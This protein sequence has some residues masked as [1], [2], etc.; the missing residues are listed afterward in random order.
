MKLAITLLCENPHRLT[1]LSSLFPALVRES[2][3]LFP[4]VEW[5]V[6]AGAK[7]EWPFEDPRVRIVRDFPANDRLPARLAA[8]HFKVGP[9][10]AQMGARALLTVG[11]VPMRAPLPVAMHVVALQHL[12][13]AGRLGWLRARYRAWALRHGVR[14]AH[15]IIAN[16]EHTRSQLMGVD[17]A[18]PLRII[19]SPEGFDHS[20][21]HADSTNDSPWP[22][23]WRIDRGYVLWLS[24]FYPYKRADR[25]L[26]AFARLP[27]ELRARHPL[28]FVGGAWGG[29]EQAARRT[30][31]ALGLE[32]DTRFLGRVPD[33]R[34]PALY[35][36][37]ALHVLSSEDETFGRTVLE[38][39]A[40]GC[41][42]LAQHLAAVREVGGKAV[43]FTD[44][45]HVEEAGTALRWVL[46]DQKYAA[47]LRSD[48]LVRA[49]HFG[50]ERLARERVGAILEGLR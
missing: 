1:G 14:R 3:R 16:S 49:Q 40:C 38:A 8:D 31:R 27:A 30:A 12:T 11:F 37:A 17:G 4:Q 2:L 46:E 10:A 7:Q 9:A 20:R 47:A 41:P 21:F 13:P 43:A 35:R 6:Y 26:A 24:N 23:E 34:L 33:D 15:W 44:F 45:A 22:V 42:C 36:R 32:R 19:V 5:I 50:F 39:M 28:V 18:E 25:A 29:G 48:G